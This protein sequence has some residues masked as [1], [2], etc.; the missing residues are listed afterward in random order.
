MPT[1][2]PPGLSITLL[3]LILSVMV[4]H[5]QGPFPPP[6]ELPARPDLPDPLMKTDGTK[7]TTAEEWPARRAE[8]LAL[9]RHYVYGH[10][11][12]VRAAWVLQVETLFV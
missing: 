5:G 8:I 3:A 12:H 7:V 4:S 1:L 9:F 10:A 11:A 2:V 6:S